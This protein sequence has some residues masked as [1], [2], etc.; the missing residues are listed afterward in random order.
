MSTKKCHLSS[1]KI[2]VIL[3]TTIVVLCVRLLL[4][5]SADYN[6]EYEYYSRSINNAA[7]FL[8]KV[9]M[10]Y[11][12][13][14]SSSEITVPITLPIMNPGRNVISGQ[15]SNVEVTQS[16]TA[17]WIDRTVS[18]AQCLKQ[19]KGA[20]FLFHARKS[21][22]TTIRL[23][24]ETMSES[25]RVPLIES[26]GMSLPK[27]IR[28]NI[29]NVFAVTS[30]RHPVQRA[31][32]L[33]WYEHVMWYHDV[34]DD[35]R[36]CKTLSQWAHAWSDDNTW[37][38]NFIR[39]NKGSTYVEVENYFVKNLIGWGRNGQVTPLTRA[40]LEIAKGRLRDEF[41][42]VFITETMDNTAYT[43][44][45]YDIMGVSSIGTS[46]TEEKANEV[47][48]DNVKKLENSLAKDKAE[49]IAYLTEIN[50]FDIELWEFAMELS[51][52]RTRDG[53][54][55]LNSRKASTTTANC[56]NNHV[57]L[58]SALRPITGIFRPPGHKGPF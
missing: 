55:L 41:D 6:H 8:D 28:L 25:L 54:S 20:L 13:L 51:V 16:N 21:A 35:M 7:L 24:L 10:S 31:L 5:T 45:F 52:N 9:K 2:I 39:K 57:K 36:D 4:N 43:S 15:S 40:D 17:S 38:Q 58:V 18:K 46:Q 32:S 42:F 23:F 34:K 50:K 56:N 26:E 30:I 37:K 19:R 1:S 22:G 12:L 44:L 14:N 3:L 27:D 33:Y 53:T 29:A 47:N 48:R 11:T 49:V